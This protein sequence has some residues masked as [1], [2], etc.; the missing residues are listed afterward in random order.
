[1]EL[2]QNYNRNS[3]TQLPVRTNTVT[4]EVRFQRSQIYDILL[5]NVTKIN[6]RV[7]QF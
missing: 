2:F 3:R 4:I 5:N 1:M 7:A 6:K